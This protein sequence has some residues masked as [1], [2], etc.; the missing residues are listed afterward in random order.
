VPWGWLTLAFA[1]PDR[2]R[3]H[4]LLREAK[5][6]KLSVEGVRYE[7]Q[8]L[9][10]SNRRGAGGRTPRAGTPHGAGPALGEL[11]RQTQRW[12]AFFRNVWSK[13]PPDELGRLAETVGKEGEAAR[14][15]LTRVAG[16]LKE[17]ADACAEAKRHA[18]EA[19]RPSK[20]GGQGEKA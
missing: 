15:A 6:E 1:V 17:L 7:V 18:R 10:K 12:L 11:E 19:R 4:E 14:A 2:E 5:K 8:N 16:L 20:E 3:R 13:V 9:T